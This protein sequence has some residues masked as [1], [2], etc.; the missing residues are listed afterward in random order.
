MVHT[1]K[2]IIMH[3]SNEI[4]K[5]SDEEITKLTEEKVTPIEIGLRSDKKFLSQCH[6]LI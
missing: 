2:G 3:R 5:H 4:Q 1:I 6:I